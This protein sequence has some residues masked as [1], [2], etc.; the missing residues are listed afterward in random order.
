VNTIG[1]ILAAGASTR[2]SQRKQLLTY[3]NKTLINTIAS[4]AEKLPLAESVC[5]TGYLHKELQEALK[6]HSISLIPNPNY[7]NGMLSSL[8]VAVRK[9]IEDQSCD[10]IL[11]MLSDQP[12]ITEYHYSSLL[13]LANKR[14]ENIIATAYRETFGVPVIYKRKHFE[15]ILELENQPTKTLIKNNLDDSLFL[16]CEEAAYDIDTDQDYQNLIAGKYE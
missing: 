13:N 2:M 10:A 7:Q 6:G 9:I 14:N 5:V 1:I 16:R 8:Q 3:K 11:I 15:K 12:L 4:L